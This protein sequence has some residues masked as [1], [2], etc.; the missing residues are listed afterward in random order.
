MVVIGNG[1]F[2]SDQYVANAQQNVVFAL[3][4]VDWLAQD[5]ALVSI[6]SKNRTPP[7]LTFSSATKRDLAKYANLMGVP[8]L[9][10]VVGIV[11][12]FRRRNRTCR[13]YTPLTEGA[14]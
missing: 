3:N 11:R 12:V 9:V 5:E 14:A 7:A 1:D 2:V 8:I 6:R 4:A 10:I 13:S